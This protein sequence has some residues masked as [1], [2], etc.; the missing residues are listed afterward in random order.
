M[1]RVEVNIVYHTFSRLS[2]PKLLNYYVLIG[3]LS[4]HTNWNLSGFA[5]LTIDNEQLTIKESLRDDLK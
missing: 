3:L 2:P 5:E 4:K 1:Q